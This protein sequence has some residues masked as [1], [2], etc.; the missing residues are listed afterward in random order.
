MSSD[1]EQTLCG[2]ALS[3][4]SD[5]ARNC[6]AQ[7]P[8]WG[9]ESPRRFRLAPSPDAGGAD[10][11]AQ[12]QTGTVRL[13]HSRLPILQRID[14]GLQKVQALIL[15]PTREL[16]IQVAQATHMYGRHMG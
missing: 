3:R 1:T 2:Y 11:L 4:H 14:L 8:M 7:F 9:Y 15:C 13:R 6:C 5:C 10:V 16:A 12:A